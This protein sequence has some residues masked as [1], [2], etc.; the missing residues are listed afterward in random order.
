MVD[1]P[2]RHPDPTTHTM[3]T[4]SQTGYCIGG[5]L[6]GHRQTLPAGVDHWR[7][8]H[9]DLYPTAFD[10]QPAP[11]LRTSTYYVM[12]WSAPPAQPEPYL[13]HETVDP[14]VLTPTSW[15]L[16]PQWREGPR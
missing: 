7:V 12:L 9:D 15:P 10:A 4:A 16:F 8:A 2:H 13:V 14:K 1:H 3:T 5:P 11:T 6:H